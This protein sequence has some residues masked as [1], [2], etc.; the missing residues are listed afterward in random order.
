MNIETV[1]SGESPLGAKGV[2]RIFVWGGGHPADATR[3][4]F[5]HLRCRPDSV[6]GGGLVADIFRD[7]HGRT[8]FSGDQSN[9]LNSGTFFFTFPGHLHGARHLWTLTEIPGDLAG[10]LTHSKNVTT[11]IRCTQKNS[12]AMLSRLPA[13]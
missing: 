9:Y 1:N 4:I 5:R 3:Y 10:L 13:T 6:G 2:A 11:S 7:L 8:T 12:Q